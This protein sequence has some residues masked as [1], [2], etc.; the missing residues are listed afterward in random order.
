MNLQHFLS[1]G[2]LV[3]FLLVDF[4]FLELCIALVGRFDWVSPCGFEF[5]DSF[6]ESIAFIHPETL[7]RPLQKPPNKRMIVMSYFETSKLCFVEEMMKLEFLGSKTKRDN[8]KSANDEAFDLAE[9]WFT[10]LTELEGMIKDPLAIISDQSGGKHGSSSVSDDKRLPLVKACDGVKNFT[11]QPDIM[12]VNVGDRESTFN[13]VSEVSEGVNLL[14]LPS[15]VNLYESGLI[16]SP[17]FQELAEKKRSEEPH[18][19]AVKSSFVTKCILGLFTILSTVKNDYKQNTLSSAST[20]EQQSFL[21]P[22]NKLIA[23]RKV[24]ILFLLMN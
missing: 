7:I 17:R 10:G 20:H 8:T 4:K 14:R 15:M 3:T 23:K 18:P 13:Q 6:L 11:A 1:L 12:K 16:I 2:C 5:L 24:S 22:F 9:I 19:E 21:F